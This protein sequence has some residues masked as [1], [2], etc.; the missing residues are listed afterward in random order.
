MERWR[1]DTTE[2]PDALRF[3]F[4]Y[5]NSD[6]DRLNTELHAVR[7]ERGQ[8]GD[9]VR[10]DTKHGPTDFAV[11]DRVQFTDTLKASKI[12]NGN[13]GTVTGID[14]DIGTARARLDSAGAGARGGVA[15]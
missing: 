12:Y 13:A 3:V 14:A 11:G 7:R 6:V 1:A 9:D 8:L 10:L 15:G 4:A 2:R 5:T